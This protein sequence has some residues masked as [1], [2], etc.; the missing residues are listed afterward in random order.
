MPCT[1]I[2]LS[3]QHFISFKTSFSFL[4]KLFLGFQILLGLN[5]SFF[6]ASINS[7]KL[8]HFVSIERNNVDVVNFFLGGYGISLISS[9]VGG[10][11]KISDLMLTLL[12]G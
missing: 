11:D 10:Y 8:L 9:T 1:R 6:V 12:N 2:T 5:K 4:F 3:S 7:S